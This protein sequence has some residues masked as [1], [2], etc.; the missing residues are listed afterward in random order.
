MQLL[1]YVEQRLFLKRLLVDVEDDVVKT[2]VADTSYDITKRHVYN[3]P[4]KLD[5]R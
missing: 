5:T 3:G 4:K 1:Q 2:L